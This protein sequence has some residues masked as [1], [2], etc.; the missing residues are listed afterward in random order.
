MK[1]FENISHIA[2]GT[3]RKQQLNVIHKQVY[4]EINI[5]SYKSKYMKFGNPEIILNKIK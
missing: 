5:K 2:L 1:K 3:V 4:W